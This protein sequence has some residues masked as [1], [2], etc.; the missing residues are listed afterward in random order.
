MCS[1]AFSLKQSLNRHINSSHEGKNN[2]GVLY[3]LQ[4][5][6]HHKK[7]QVNENIN[8][9]QMDKCCNCDEATE[10]LININK[11]NLCLPCSVKCCSQFSLELDPNAVN[12]YIK[13]HQTTIEPIIKQ[14]PNIT[15]IKKELNEDLAKQAHSQPPAIYVKEEN[16]G[17]E[18]DED[19]DDPLM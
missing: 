5:F 10:D 15:D 6:R 2:S 19:I 7:H 8:E 4:Y 9:G 11:K 17:N 14:E 12:D 3:A 1:A 18:I 16:S 13:K